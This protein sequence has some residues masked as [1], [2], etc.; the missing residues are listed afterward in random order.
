MLFEILILPIICYN[1]VYRKLNTKIPWNQD[2]LCLLFQAV[3]ARLLQD[4]DS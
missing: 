4:A 3:V 1:Y 2:Y